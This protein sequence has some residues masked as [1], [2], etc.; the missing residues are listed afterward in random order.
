MNAAPRRN[1]VWLA[2]LDKVRPVAVLTRDPLGAVLHSVMVAP[3]TSTVRGLET[4]VA[5]GV[6]DDI[7]RPSVANLDNVQPIDR[8]RLDRRVVR[9]RPETMRA[10]CAA[11]SVAVGCSGVQRT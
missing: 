1:E 7:W 10:I 4:E 3:V 11:I 2:L 9:V 6:D 5:L 8:S